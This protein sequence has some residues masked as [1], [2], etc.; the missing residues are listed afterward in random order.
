MT[1]FRSPREEFLETQRAAEELLISI[2]LVQKVSEH[3][4]DRLD[5]L[6]VSCSK[7][8]YSNGLTNDLSKEIHNLIAW[9]DHLDNPTIKEDFR[10]ALKATPL[11]S[12]W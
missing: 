7:L 12:P 9:C 4:L 10:N 11:K 6:A 5:K 1:Q 2:S 3:E 8:C